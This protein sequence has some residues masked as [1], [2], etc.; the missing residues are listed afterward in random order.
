M[1]SPNPGISAA[2]EDLSRTALDPSAGPAAIGGMLSPGEGEAEAPPPPPARPP[3]NDRLPALPTVIRERRPGNALEDRLSAVVS[4]ISNLVIALE[5]LSFRP[6]GSAPPPPRQGR[7]EAGQLPPI[8][9]ETT[10][11]TN[12]G[13]SA[14]GLGATASSTP[15]VA[16][17][18]R[19]P[20]TSSD[21]HRQA[22]SHHRR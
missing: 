14:Y 1:S 2:G 7:D 21:T 22:A 16:G 4:D 11:G 10:P 9:P 12:Y 19:L 8:S 6:L 18:A 3:I 20:M 17:Y 13:H 5:A 15:Q